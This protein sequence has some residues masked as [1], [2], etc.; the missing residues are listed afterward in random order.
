L[1]Y[2]PRGGNRNVQ[3][4]CSGCARC[5]QPDT[6]T[7]LSGVDDLMLTNRERADASIRAAERVAWAGR[8]TAAGQESSCHHEERVRLTH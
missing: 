1:G 2:L 5:R 7:G 4:L 8:V 3:V 6:R